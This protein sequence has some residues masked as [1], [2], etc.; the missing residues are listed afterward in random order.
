MTL[1]YD[2]QAPRCLV[3]MHHGAL[4]RFDSVHHAIESYGFTIG[5]AGTP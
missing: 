2:I 1:L 5:Q 3:A 4:L